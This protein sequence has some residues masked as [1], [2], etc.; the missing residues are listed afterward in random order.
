MRISERE[1]LEAECNELRYMLSMLSPEEWAKHPIGQGSLLHRLEEVERELQALE[2]GSEPFCLDLTFRGA[3]VE[4]SRSIAAS[5][6]GKAT[7]LFSDA[8]LALYAGSLNPELKTKGPVPNKAELAPRI[9][10]T[11]R[12]SFGFEFEFPRVEASEQLGLFD[13]EAALDP[14]ATLVALVDA[15]SRGQEEEVAEALSR[16]HDR[17]AQKLGAFAAYVAKQEATFG[18]ST[19]T[20]R[21]E[22][23][24][25]EVARRMGELLGDKTREGEELLEGVLSGVLPESRRFELRQH[26]GGRVITGRIDPAL[27]PGQEIL[28]RWQ[29]QPVRLRARVIRVG[30]AQRH[31]ALGLEALDGAP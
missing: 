6:A 3:P 9:V 22:V 2:P 15:A 7:E 14:A 20:R 30:A 12:G 16:V 24:S 8:G 13:G 10:G 11:V 5:F 4:G 21:V 18:V 25:A 27:G 17:A 31:V 28:T 23:P 29:G 1:F 19:A 26:E